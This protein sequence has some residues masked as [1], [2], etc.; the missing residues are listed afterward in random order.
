MSFGAELIWVWSRE[1]ARCAGRRVQKV[2]GAGSSVILSF[3]SAEMLLSWGAQNCG[4]S[5]IDGADKKLI[6]S[7]ARQLPPIT[8][9]LK[10]HLGGAELTKVEQLRRDRILKFSFSKTVGAGFANVRSLVLEIME[11]FSNLLL[12]DENDVILETAKHIYPADNDFRTVL[13]GCPYHLPPEFSG[14]SLEGWLE[15]PSSETV[16]GVAGFG[17]PLL[18]AASEMD[19][20]SAA[21]VLGAFY[22]DGCEGEFITQRLGKYVTALPV[23]LDGAERCADSSGRLLTVAP[24]RND[25]LEGRR[26]KIRKLLEKEATRRERQLAD[27]DALLSDTKHELYKK[28]GE[29]IVA[30]LWQIR[31]GLSEAKLSGYG[32]DGAEFSLEVPLDPK[33]SPSQNAAAYFA[34]YKKITAAQERAFSLYDKVRGEL[35]DLLEELEMAECLDDSDSMAMTEEELGLARR[36]AGKRSSKKREQHLPPHKRFEF[37]DALV[38]AGLSSKGNRYLTFKLA[39]PDDLWFH[40]QGVPGSHVL[41]RLTSSNVDGGRLEELKNFCASLAVCYS[42]G[43]EGGRRRVDCTLRKH[44]SPI[45]GGVANV[46]YK[47]FSTLTGEPAFWMEFLKKKQVI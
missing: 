2:E 44:V 17:R 7:S 30:N 12:L 15:A 32:E 5:L 39:S 20:K 33:I 4:A 45:R 3:G 38:Y 40:T 8:N 21:A 11:R 47:E 14:L 31:H 27:I 46:T 10:S 6:V 25:A 42:K 23:M 1:L 9:A 18:R 16:T 36:D 13:P 35:D 34:K 41:L 24:L 43:S 19:L 22:R 26:K 37:E 29:L 28:Y